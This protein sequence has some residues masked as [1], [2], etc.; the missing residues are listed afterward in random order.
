MDGASRSALGEFKAMILKKKKVQ[1]GVCHHPT[2]VRRLICE[3]EDER[4]LRLLIVMD[5][6]ITDE[7]R[8]P[9]ASIDLAKRTGE[10]SHSNII[11]HNIVDEPL[12]RRWA[13]QYGMGRVIASRKGSGAAPRPATKP[14]SGAGNQDDLKVIRVYLDSDDKFWPL[15]EESYHEFL[16]DFLVQGEGS[17]DVDE[18]CHLNLYLGR[19]IAGSRWAIKN[20]AVN[21]EGEGEERIVAVARTPPNLNAMVAVKS[22]MDN[23]GWPEI[24]Q[25]M[26]PTYDEALI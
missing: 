8:L 3:Y 25:E 6:R 9:P 5:G 14:R 20:V 16:W 1:L 2:E 12:V 10:K 19:N 24:I 15:V 7:L 23:Y 11:L 17:A 22:L 18:K 26:N 21:D 4:A 13:S